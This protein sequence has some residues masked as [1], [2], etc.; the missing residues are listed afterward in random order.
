MGG[1]CDNLGKLASQCDV[2]GFCVTGGL[3]L[4]LE[5]QVTTFT[6]AAS[7]I[8]S[9]GYDDQNTGATINPDGTYA[10][11]AAVFTAATTP[12]E[13]KVNASGLSVALRCTM[14]VDAGGPDGVG[15]PDEAS[16]TPDG[17]L[18]TFDIQ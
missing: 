9:F 16:P 1:V 10:L 11:P 12:N 7:G 3:P 18:I 2:N 13:I 5:S 14:A 6:A 4:A 15:V 8:V 17:L